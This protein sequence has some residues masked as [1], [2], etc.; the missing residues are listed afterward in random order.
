MMVKDGFKFGIGY[1]LGM[2]ILKVAIEE[3]STILEIYCP[4]DSKEK[5]KE[6]TE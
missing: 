4:K 1:V 5:S 2:A 3:L 6:T